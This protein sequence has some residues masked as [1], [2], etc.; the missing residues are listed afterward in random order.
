[1]CY[2]CCESLKT[3]FGELNV[4]SDMIIEKREI[5][6][7]NGA[8][9]ISGMTIE[10]IICD[11]IRLLN[12]PLPFQVHKFEKIVLAAPHNLNR[13]DMA[14]AAN[15]FGQSWNF[16]TI[17]TISFFFYNNNSTISIS[18]LNLRRKSCLFELHLA[19]GK[20]NCWTIEDGDDI[21]VQAFELLSDAM[22]YIRNGKT[23]IF[24]NILNMVY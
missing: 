18:S 12:S 6:L 1:M 21:L 8:L 22:E 13:T 14:T 9:K 24:I 3:D 16:S 10:K 23:N 5:K 7:K 2:A 11:G 19:R 17:S 4:T 20:R 15:I